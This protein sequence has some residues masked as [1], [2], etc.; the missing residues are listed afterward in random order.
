LVKK[1]K[2]G[3][4]LY[5]SPSDFMVGTIMNRVTY[6]FEVNVAGENRGIIPDE[7]LHLTF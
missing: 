4:P 6:D 2:K 3:Q 1:W 5:A 7:V